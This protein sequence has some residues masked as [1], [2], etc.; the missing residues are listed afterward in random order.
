MHNFRNI[1][2]IISAFG[3]VACAGS[4]KQDVYTGQTVGQTKPISLPVD[5]NKADIEGQY[6]IPKNVQGKY[7]QN[8]KVSAQPPTVNK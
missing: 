3:L 6:Q 2:I 1:L 7:N 5:L 4:H 8:V